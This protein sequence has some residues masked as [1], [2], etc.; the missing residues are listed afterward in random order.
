[1]KRTTALPFL[2]GIFGQC[3]YALLLAVL[4]HLG[5][6][7]ELFG[8]SFGFWGMGAYLLAVGVIAATIWPERFWI[9]WLGGLAAW[10]ASSIALMPWSPFAMLMP[11]VYLVLTPASWFGSFIGYAIGTKIREAQENGSL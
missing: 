1:M 10:F 6:P 2:F 7:K 4:V 3:F 8:D 5:V 11:M 9:A